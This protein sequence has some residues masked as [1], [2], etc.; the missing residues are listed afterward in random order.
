MRIVV[1]G[2][3]AMG[4]LYGGL[5][6]RNGVDVVLVDRWEAHVRAI[7]AHGLHLDGITGDLNI[8]IEATMAPDAGFA[9]IALIQVD[10]NA[11]RSAAET[12]AR[13][14]KPEGW[15]ITLQNGVGNLEILHQILGQDRVLGGLSYHSA[16][17][18]GPGHVSH[19]H[20]GPTWLGE[21]D[22]SIS[23]RATMFSELLASAGFAPVVVDN[24]EGHIWSKFIHN[25]AINPICA[26]LGQRV[27]EIPLTREADAL[28]SKIIEEALAVVRAKGI[29]LT[30]PDPM[31]TIKEFCKTKFNKPSMLQHM[32]AA[33]R[34]EIDALNG[35]VVREGE[36][37]DIATPYNRA[38][39]WMVKGM[40]R[41]RIREREAGPFDYERL[42]AE[43][44]A[45]EKSP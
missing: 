13:A 14:L 24:I 42:E 12:A 21:L 10:T 41:Q 36:N 6:A 29:A 11:T 8:T 37:L 33:K 18:Q 2:A 1:I 22:G 3:G 23:K 40:E 17:V 34:T 28:Q 45:R 38:V 43:A 16:L 26:V 15:A 5:L 27:G 44:I 19:T 30:D 25:A 4:S 7:R 20:A 9:D 35:A 32:E 39:M 31:K